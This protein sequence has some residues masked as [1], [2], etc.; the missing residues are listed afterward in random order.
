MEKQE[1][2]NSMPRHTTEFLRKRKFFVVLPLLV[3]P[4]MTMA[5]V[6]LDGGKTVRLST[7]LSPEKGI[8]MALPSAQ[9]KDGQARG[10]MDIYRTAAKDSSTSQAGIS[11]GFIQSMGFGSR[12]GYHDDSAA[13]DRII[14]PVPGN[15]D[16]QSAKIEA[17]L[18]Q[19]NRQLNQPQPPLPPTLPYPEDHTEALKNVGQIKKMINDMN[20]DT[21]P[22]P[23]LRQL[24]K[25]ME[26][27]QSMQNAPAVKPPVA[28]VEADTM[29]FKAIPAIIDGKQKVVDGGEVRLRLTD[30]VTLKTLLLPK[31]QL[32]YGACQVT[33]QRLLL[34]VKNIRLGNHIIPVDLTVF[35]LDGLPGIPAH[36][37]ELTGAAT[38][39]ADNTLSGMQLLSMDQ[40][41][42]AQA[43]AGGIQAAKGLFSRKMKKVRVKLED[44]FP[45]LLRDNSQK[46]PVNIP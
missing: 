21:T 30:S 23:E 18:Q 35:S 46:T 17:R 39:G 1:A 31:G 42:G 24:G 6:A 36:E 10:K 22:D 40:S 44:K 29:P 9:F 15:A 32:L 33:N 34:S 37:A 28:K 7:S 41:L 2:D 13:I 45:I 8:D 26:Q 3:L 25:M 16:R 4:F 20:S 43:A 19:I 14:S 38:G 27:L 11:K 5:F 12:S